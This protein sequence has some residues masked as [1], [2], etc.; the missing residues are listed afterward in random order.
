MRIYIVVGYAFSIFA[1]KCILNNGIIL[2]LVIIVTIVMIMFER[3]IAKVI[4]LYYYKDD[5]KVS[6]EKL[7]NYVAC[8]ILGEDL[9]NLWNND[10]KE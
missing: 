10:F 6:H 9:Q 7:P 4:A 8:E 2:I 3:K 5:M 1:D